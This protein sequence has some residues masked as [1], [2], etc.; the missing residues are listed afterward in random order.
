MIEALLARVA[1]LEA[2]ISTDGFKTGMDLC[3]NAALQR[4]EAFEAKSKINVN[5]IVASAGRR[6]HETI[7]NCV[8]SKMQRDIVKDLASTRAA[9]VHKQSKAMS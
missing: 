9:R 2:T 6:Q 1:A 7:T 8:E 4:I 5:R 3:C